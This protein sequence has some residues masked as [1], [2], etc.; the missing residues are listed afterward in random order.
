[1]ESLIAPP[2]T[3]NRDRAIFVTQLATPPPTV[4]KPRLMLSIT[5]PEFRGTTFPVD[6]SDS[7]QWRR[8]EKIGRPE[9]PIPRRNE[10]PQERLK[11]LSQPKYASPIPP[12]EAYVVAI[13]PEYKGEEAH[14]DY[15][16]WLNDVI[17]EDHMPEIIRRVNKFRGF[18]QLDNPSYNKNNPQRWKEYYESQTAQDELAPYIHWINASIEQEK[19]EKDFE[20]Q[21]SLR[22]NNRVPRSASLLTFKLSLKEARGARDLEPKRFVTNLKRF[23]SFN[24]ANSLGFKD[25]LCEQLRQSIRNHESPIKRTVVLYNP[26]ASK[27]YVVNLASASVSYV[28]IGFDQ[29]N[30]PSTGLLWLSSGYKDKS[31][32]PFIKVETPVS[33][34]SPYHGNVAGV[35]MSSP[36]VP[37]SVTVGRAGVADDDIL[38]DGFVVDINEIH[39]PPHGNARDTC[40]DYPLR[41]WEAPFA[42]SS[43]QALCPEVKANM[44]RYELMD[45]LETLPPVAN[46]LL[47]PSNAWDPAPPPLDTT[48]TV[49]YYH[50]PPKAS[51]THIN[52]RGSHL[53]NA[54]NNLTIS[55]DPMTPS[56]MGFVSIA[57]RPPM[58]H[59]FTVL[60]AIADGKRKYPDRGSPGYMKNGNKRVKRRRGCGRKRNETR[61][62]DDEYADDELDSDE[63]LE[64]LRTG[65]RVRKHATGTRGRKSHKQPTK[66][67][68]SIRDELMSD[69]GAKADDEATPTRPGSF[70]VTSTS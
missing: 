29:I 13:H 3:P 50:V 34:S 38:S 59:P 18:P 37:T 27:S 10:T 16:T 39:M 66:A 58:P 42:W 28:P 70:L 64:R 25:E 54:S 24:S 23:N 57:G 60:K 49:R 36:G 61:G 40:I 65:P 14:G 22:S 67:D 45:G 62:P 19:R 5:L 12:K 21:N 69:A 8:R 56:H 51:A 44:P 33:P 26:I 9:R 41:S 48:P 20:V 30:I 6:S 47:N 63:P 2:K 1:M 68:P 32:S 53:G 55:A 43:S 4:P 17:Y 35:L 11:R 46:V 31:T 7:I 52:A 15:Y